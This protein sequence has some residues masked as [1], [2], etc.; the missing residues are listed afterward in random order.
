[1]LSKRH[2]G[3]RR[4]PEG[5]AMRSE[6]LD[7]GVRRNDDMSSTLFRTFLCRNTSLATGPAGLP[8]RGVSAGFRKANVWPCAARTGET[9]AS[10]PPAGARPG[11]ALEAR[12][13]S[14][15]RRYGD[16]T[17]LS[18]IP[19]YAGMTARKSAPDRDFLRSLTTRRPMPPT[20]P[21]F[22]TRERKPH[23]AAQ[24]SA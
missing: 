16:E 1:M 14:R 12:K 22:Q 21:E 5:D 8:Q 18:W 24:F 7:S 10:P 17:G 19:A 4:Y 3:E 15:R 13:E 6:I 2:T 11:A 20:C 23:N 9:L